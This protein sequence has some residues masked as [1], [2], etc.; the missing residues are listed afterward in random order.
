MIKIDDISILRLLPNFLQ[1]DQEIKLLIQVIQEEFDL[2]NTKEK[3]L[4]LYGD[5]KV[6]DEAVLDELAYQWKTEG[7]EQ[8][9][10]KEIKAHLVESSYIVR[11]TKGTAYAVEKTVKSIYGNFKLL[12]WWESGLDPY[13]FKIVGTS[14][15]T[16]DKLAEIYKAINM[17]K[18]ERSHL[19]GI[20]VSNQWEG[21]NYQGITIH[22]GVF[23]VIPFSAESIAAA[24]QFL[25]G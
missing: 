1:E 15:P 9:F 25:G 11:K 18:N 7:Y 6:L 17:T 8:T 24:E 13:H 12:E 19:A 21:T 2:I 14:S 20:L 5:F 23:E 22:Q 4:F 16:G 3:N 10:S